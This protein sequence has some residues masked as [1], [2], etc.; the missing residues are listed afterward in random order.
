[1]SLGSTTGNTDNHTTSIRIPIWS[2]QTYECRNQIYTAGVT[3][4]LSNPLRIRS[5]VYHASA[6]TEPLNSRTCYED[7]TLKSILNLAIQAPSNSSYQP[8]LGIID[9][10]T[11]IHQHEA[12]STIGVLSLAWVEAVLTKEGSLLVTCSTCNRD[13]STQ[14]SWISIA[15]YAGRRTNLWQHGLRNSQIA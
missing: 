6:I 5:R 12:A 3:N 1:M 9:V 8:I 10:S 2:T 4:L 13:W 15:I 7:G 14:N 11:G